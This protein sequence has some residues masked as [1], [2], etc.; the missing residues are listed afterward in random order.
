VR[1]ENAFAVFLVEGTMMG[2][3]QPPPPEGSYPQPKKY[4]AVTKKR[5]LS[6]KGHS[7]HLIAT[8]FT[9]GAW[10]PVWFC[11]WAFRWFVRRKQ[12]TTYRM[13]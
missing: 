10:A 5:G 4:V 7:G 8:I 1:Q 2:R 9:C 13:R 3:S 12:K 6:A 11:W